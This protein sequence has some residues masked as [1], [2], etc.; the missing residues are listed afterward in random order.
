MY[1]N[2]AIP[3]QIEPEDTGSLSTRMVAQL[4]DVGTMGGSVHS[5]SAEEFLEK[6]ASKLYEKG[7]SSGGGDPPPKKFLG[8]SYSDWAKMVIGW[9][10]AL[11]AFLGTWY[12]TVRDGLAE[13]PTKVEVGAD[14]QKVINDHSHVTHPGTEKRIEA[15]EKEQRTIRESQIRQ[16]EADKG[17]TATL[18][19]IKEELVRIRR[20]Q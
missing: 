5:D 18:G 3:Q 14:V 20:R 10:V 9:S 1:G 16:E 6:L 2:N 7:G 13:R 12:M 4:A 11:L 15:I 8:L 17:Q 19:E